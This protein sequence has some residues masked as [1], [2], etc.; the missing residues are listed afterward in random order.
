MPG[1]LFDKLKM[2]AT[3]WLGRRLPACDE[4]TLLMSE[5]LERKLSVREQVRLRLHFLI[6]GCCKWYLRQLRT[7]RDAARERAEETLPDAT[8]STEAR[9]RIRRALAEREE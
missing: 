8:L 7:M 1:G 5:S 3:F 6:C 9:E 4:L 2:E